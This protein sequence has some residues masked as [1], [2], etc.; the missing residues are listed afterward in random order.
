MDRAGLLNL[1]SDYLWPRLILVQGEGGARVAL[2]ESLNK[3]REVVQAVN[4]PVVDLAS[5]R[6]TVRPHAAMRPTSLT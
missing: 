3:D 2:D 1:I 4:R 6:S 5:R